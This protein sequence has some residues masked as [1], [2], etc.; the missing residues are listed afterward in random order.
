MRR[1]G[2]QKTKRPVKVIFELEQDENGYPPAETEFLWCIPTERGTYIVDNLPFFV[3]EISLGDEIAAT[4]IGKTLQFSR[5]VH[6][7]KNSTIR[8][9]LK[10]TAM[11]QEIRDKL[12]AL[13]CGTELMD[14][15]SLLSVTMPSDAKITDTLSFLDAEAEQGNIGI[16][17]SAVRYQNLE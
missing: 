13:G 2:K 1:A 17:E 14:K 4:R 10:N 3:R 9:L 5:V 8:V 12:D 11:I 6:Q 16:E 7:S 15:L